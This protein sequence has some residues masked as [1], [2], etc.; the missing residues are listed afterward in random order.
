MGSLRAKT[1]TDQ[2]KQPWAALL[3]ADH[4]HDH[5]SW[6]GRSHR[7]CAG[8]AQPHRPM[9]ASGVWATAAS[10]CVIGDQPQISGASSRGGS[11]KVD[12]NK[13]LGGGYLTLPEHPAPSPASAT[14]G[15]AMHA[16]ASQRTA[17][18]VFLDRRRHHSWSM[19]ESLYLT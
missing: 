8:R 9:R 14:H 1:R 7:Y 12:C 10:A 19:K 18:T 5:D 6:S 2:R 17:C 13:R 15:C 11:L 3:Q 16:P 4:D